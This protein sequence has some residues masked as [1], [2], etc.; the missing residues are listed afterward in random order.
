MFKNIIYILLASVLFISCEKNALQLPIETITTGA[1]IKFIHAAPDTPPV[2]FYINGAK[3][4][5]F[6]P[7]GATSTF[8]G[9]PVGLPY[10]TT[11]P[12]FASNYAIVTPGTVSLSVTAPATTTAASATAVGS[13]SL[14]LE[15]NKYYSLFVAGPTTKPELL[16]VNDDFSAAIDPTKIYV[17]FINLTSGQNYDIGLGTGTIL[18]P[19]LAYK[20]VTGFIAVDANTVPTFTFRLPGSATNVGTVTLGATSSGRVLTVFTRGVAGR[21]GTPAPGINLYVNR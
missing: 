21:T 20:G 6:T 11:S 2:D 17:R 19:N 12:S 10:N 4:T 18:A 1:R 9:N 16:L 7:T 8:A 3:F 15:D 14:T 13:Q 5:G